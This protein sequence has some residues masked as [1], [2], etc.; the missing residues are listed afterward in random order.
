MHARS[1]AEG[2]TYSNALLEMQ[3]VVN[4]H[5]KAAWTYGHI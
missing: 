5:C 2:V 4:P 1:L 3:F